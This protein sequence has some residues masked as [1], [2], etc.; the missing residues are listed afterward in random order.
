ML[1]INMIPLGVIKLAMQF[2]ISQ[3]IGAFP[4][5]TIDTRVD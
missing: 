2:A 3:F 4:I 5:D 1:K